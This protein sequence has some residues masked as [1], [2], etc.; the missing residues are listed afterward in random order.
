MMSDL[1]ETCY[2][3]FP[4]LWCVVHVKVLKVK[5]VKVDTVRRSSPTG[6]TAPEK[7]HQSSRL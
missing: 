6:N 2:A 7:P 4:V 3:F 5:K 1:E